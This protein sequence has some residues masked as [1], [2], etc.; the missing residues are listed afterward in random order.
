MEHSAKTAEHRTIQTSWQNIITK[1]SKSPLLLPKNISIE[2]LSQLETMCRLVE[3]IS[4]PLGHLTLQNDKSYVAE[5]KEKHSDK[6]D[7]TRPTFHSLETSLEFTKVNFWQSKGIIISRPTAFNDQVGDE[8]KSNESTENSQQTIKFLNRQMELI[9]HEDISHKLSSKKNKAALTRSRKSIRCLSKEI[10]IGLDVLKNTKRRDEIFIPA[11]INNI[12]FWLSISGEKRNKK[13]LALSTAMCLFGTSLKGISYEDKTELEGDITIIKHGVKLA[14]NVYL[15]MIFHRDGP[16]PYEEMALENFIQQIKFLIPCQA[17]PSNNLMPV[18]LHLPGP[19]YFL[20]L[21]HLFLT[22]KASAQAIQQALSIIVKHEKY[23]KL[24]IQDEIKKQQLSD[25]IELNISSPFAKLT[26]NLPEQNL[27]ETF[28]KRI[29]I[30]HDN[31]SLKSSTDNLGLL[32]YGENSSAKIIEEKCAIKILGLLMDQASNLWLEP[33]LTGLQA[34]QKQS[35]TP[36]SYHKLLSD[37][38]CQTNLYRPKERET[39]LTTFEGLFRLGNA[40]Y[41]LTGPKSHQICNAQLLSEKQIQVSIEKLCR[42]L[43]IKSPLFLTTFDPIHDKDALRIGYQHRKNGA[44]FS[45][46]RMEKKPG[47]TYNDL[48]TLNDNLVTLSQP[49]LKH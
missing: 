20:I 45:S 43:K 2:D 17:N 31:Q 37:F 3:K 36:E 11:S 23:R 9:R 27:A 44:L 15:Q 25:K 22:R 5:S 13:P 30:L 10:N 38:L 12:G 28:F 42:S 16:V 1:I 34:T 26:E 46:D 18:H 47:E 14:K 24:V 21:T 32:I 29:G 7:Q 49:N 33:F 6:K 41:G 8:K 39:C 19:D 40:L 48:R 4:D 35:I